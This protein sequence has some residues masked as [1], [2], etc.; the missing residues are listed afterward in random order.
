MAHV[1]M[2]KMMRKTASVQRLVLAG[3]SVDN[4]ARPP[5]TKS[6]NMSLPLPILVSPLDFESFVDLLPIVLPLIARRLF[7]RALQM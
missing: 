3:S 4:E 7:V 5:F 2:Q 6:R 1:T